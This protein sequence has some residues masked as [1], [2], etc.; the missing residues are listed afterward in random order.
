MQIVSTGFQHGSTN[1]P[2]SIDKLGFPFPHKVTSICFQLVVFDDDLSHSVWDN[3]KFQSCFNLIFLI[4]KDEEHFFEVF[5][6]HFNFF[7]WE[8][9]VRIPSPLLNGVICFLRC[10]FWVICILCTLSHC[11]IYNWQRF[12]S[13]LCVSS[14]VDCSLAVKRM[15]SFF[16]FSFLNCWP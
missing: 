9:F 12:L 16:E 2:P 8:F 6:S 3:V 13:I 1:F 11:Q 5:I 14:S 4:A 10:L 7:F 15:S